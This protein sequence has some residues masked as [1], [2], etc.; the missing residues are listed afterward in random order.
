MKCT[1]PFETFTNNMHWPP[2]IRYTFFNPW[3]PATKL[4]TVILQPGGCHIQWEI[5][6]VTSFVCSTY[7]CS[8]SPHKNLT[9][10]RG[11]G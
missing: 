8:F 3:L 2:P 6:A 7:Y 10:P 9:K 4:P 1:L 11:I 5:P